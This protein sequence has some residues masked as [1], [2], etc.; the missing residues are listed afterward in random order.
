MLYLQAK[1]NGQFTT[2]ATAEIL[3]AESLVSVFWS[4]QKV[5]GD[6]AGMRSTLKTLEK[7]YKAKHKGAI[8]KIVDATEKPEKTPKAA[9]RSAVFFDGLELTEEYNGD[10]ELSTASDAASDADLEADLSSDDES[11]EETPEAESVEA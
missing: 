6:T 8:T 10:L 3:G 7:V 1:I 9:K 2:I 11:T 5:W 4:G